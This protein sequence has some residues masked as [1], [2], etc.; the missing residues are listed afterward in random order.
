[1]KRQISFAE[2]EGHGQKRVTRRQRFLAEMER[3]VPW[4]RLIAA[5]EPYYPKGKRGRPPIGLERMLRIYFLQQWYGLSDEA[6]E[7]ALYDS[8]ALRAFAGIDLAVEA[9]PDATTLLKFRRM[10]VEHELTRKLFDEIG[11]M[12]CERGLMMKEGTIVD[13]TIIAAPPSTKNETKSRD[14]EMHQTKKG[15]A[16]HFGMK[17]H[18]GV[19]A[20]SGLVHSVVGTAANESDVSQAHAL[21]H[22]HEEHAFGDAGYTGV[23]KRD[24]MQGKSV[25]WQVA[26][27]R[28]KIKAMREGI[29]KDLLIAVERAKAQIRARVEHP[30]HVIKNLFGHRKVRYKGL[31]KNT[32]QLFS[33][34]GLA[35]LVLAKK[36]L[37]ALPGNSPR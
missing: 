14:P 19:D 21:L 13:A 37:L 36:Q 7:D 18:V 31:A 25:K 4:S 8:M 10:L 24:E 11:I 2:A 1:M 5:V 6:L 27:K 15:N 35:N 12:L 23:E 32:A 33:L 22:G 30:F 9:V 17:S 16:W 34:F 3:V 26:V 28:G 20:A 29:V